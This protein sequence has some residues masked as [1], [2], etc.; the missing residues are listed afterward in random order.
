[1]HVGLVATP[2]NADAK[3][4]A[5]AEATFEAAKDSPFSVD[6]PRVALDA[7]STS[8]RERKVVF[9]FDPFA[10]AAER[11]AVAA[12]LVVGRIVR[13]SMRCVAKAESPSASTITL[14]AYLVE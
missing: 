1:M 12:N 4:K 14:K 2:I 5:T 6:T 13:G 3:R 10:G 7:S 9:S 8:S 11:E